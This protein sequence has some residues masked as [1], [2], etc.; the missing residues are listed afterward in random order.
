[1]YFSICGWFDSSLFIPSFIH[2]FTQQIFIDWLVGGT[3]EDGKED[4]LPT[5]DLNGRGKGEGCQSSCR[6]PGGHESPCEEPPKL[7]EGGGREAEGSP[8]ER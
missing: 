1:M 2:L 5:G 4:A 3:R 6:C 7:L 8:G